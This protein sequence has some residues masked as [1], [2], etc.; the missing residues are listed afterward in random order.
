[1][2]D[3]VTL[4]GLVQIELP[5]A[6][7]RFCDGA[8]VKWGSDLFES[9]DPDF[10]VIG[11]MEAVEEGTGDEIPALRM[12][13]LP[14]STAAAA[15]LSQP[16]YQGCTMR[17]WIAEVDMDTNEVVGT[18]S[19]EFD[20]QVD[21]TDLVIDRGS[22][23]LEMDI[24]ARAERLFLINEANTLSPRNHKRFFPGETGEDNAVG[25]S[26][27][28]AWGTALPAQTY[29]AGFSTGSGSGGKLNFRDMIGQ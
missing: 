18:P 24:T 6:T 2:I 5:D 27:G 21:S 8:F 13:F 9:D 16:E 28:V 29:G 17:S 15:I 25:V 22:R 7:L 12:T 1:M 26:V 10:G 19:L 4:S 23:E 11:S 3:T 20:G 14:A